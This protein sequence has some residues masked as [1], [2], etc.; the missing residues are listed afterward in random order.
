[1][2]RRLTAAIV[3]VVAG[4]L[5]LAGLGTFLLVRRSAREEARRELVSQAQQLAAAPGVPRQNVI[6]LL[7]RV[8][9]LQDGV[10]VAIGPLGGIVGRLPSGLSGGDV[11]PAALLQGQTVSGRRGS[12]VFAAAPVALPAQAPVNLPR[13]LR[14]GGGAA[15]QPGAAP[16]AGGTAAVVL[17]RRVA[18]VE[19]GTGYLLL[20]SALAL[21]VAAL[22]AQYLTR[23]IARPLRDAEQATRRIAEG[24]LATQV[25]VAPDEYPELASLTRSI[26]SMAASLSRSRGLE[27]QFLMSVSHDLRTPLTSIRGF[28]EAISDGVTTDVGRAAAVIAGESRR[29]ERLVQDLLDLAKLDA[30]RFSL[31]LRE[32]DAAEV[33]GDTA[34]GFRPAADS[35][36][37]ELCVNVPEP[38]RLAVAADP[39][40]L[41][42]V[43]ANLVENAFK[44][45]LRRIDVGADA[46][47][48]DVT[49]TVADDGPGIPAEDLPHLFDRFHRSARTPARQMG[50]G[51]GL[52]I[53]AELV[54]AMAGTVEVQPP[55][56]PA[57]GTRVVVRLRASRAFA[58]ARHG[59]GGHG[60][61]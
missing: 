24:D 54:R 31:D 57:G 39:D 22:V 44:F 30:A 53:V 52:A 27:R 9:R 45:A 19:R 40:R 51:L 1:M 37:L 36:G 5:L 11:D 50:S 47:G 25:P 23:R 21:V 13:R 42:Q 8:A 48:P 59:T 14:L 16:P 28:A 46:L 29:L 35:A 55:A 61:G 58:P 3:G 56:G 32:V 49:I 26:N 41:A 20:S 34:E 2:R 60:T 6:S 38:G 17:T 4:A 43:V 12:V 7:R 18:G 10:E 15:T 33:V